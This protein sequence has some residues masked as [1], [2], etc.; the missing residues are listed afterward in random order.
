MSFNATFCPTAIVSP[1]NQGIGLVG[2][3]VGIATTLVGI[4]TLAYA[5]KALH[6]RGIMQDCG[7][8]LRDGCMGIGARVATAF[9][10]CRELGTFAPLTFTDK[11]L[12]AVAG[13]G[14]IAALPVGAVAFGVG[15]IAVAALG[16]K[17]KT[18]MDKANAAAA[19]ATAAAAADAAAAAA[20]AAAAA[21][22]LVP[23][24]GLDAQSKFDPYAGPLKMDDFA[25]TQIIGK[26]PPQIQMSDQNG[27]I[28][29][30]LQS[31]LTPR[32]MK[33]LPEAIEA[34]L[35]EHHL[36]PEGVK[37]VYIKNPG[38]SD[39]KRN[40]LVVIGR[41][42]RPADGRINN[43]DLNTL[44]LQL[45]ALGAD[46]Q[47]IN[48]GFPFHGVD[49]QKVKELLVLLEFRECCR[50]SLVIPADDVANLY[51]SLRIL[52]GGRF[53]PEMSE[54]SP[55]NVCKAISV[56]MEKQPGDESQHAVR[57]IEKP[58]PHEPEPSFTY[59]PEQIVVAMTQGYVENIQKTTKVVTAFDGSTTKY[60]LDGYLT[61]EPNAD[62]P[63]TGNSHATA[64]VG[65]RGFISDTWIHC[66]NNRVEQQN[67]QCE[68]GN[69]QH[70]K[71]AYLIFLSKA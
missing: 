27:I 65:R 6:D 11:A 35:V 55:L 29:A 4:G 44:R 49:P 64:T 71:K 25:K 50:H 5:G 37:E 39:A 47:G 53:P 33:R 26:V 59:K 67:R 52:D 63:N 40:A 41:I 7:N 12:G 70:L 62:N 17:R 10:R 58:G 38:L 1:A 2:F 22:A 57:F 9:N 69:L 32:Y 60:K 46:G 15:V 21:V 31:M 56:L 36:F 18:E 13:A 48:K 42:L 66:D 45:Q 23:F 34:Y 30:S 68:F 28:A 61:W 20:D 8:F 19:A 14:M 16:F 51:R 43:D 24:N 54:C 3:G